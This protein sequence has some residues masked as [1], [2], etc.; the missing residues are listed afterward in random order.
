MEVKRLIRKIAVLTDSCCDIP[1]ELCEKYGIDRKTMYN[2]RKME[3]IPFTRKGERGKIYYL[4]AD[5]R[6]FFADL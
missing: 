4:P 6:A 2:Y 1:P 3:L 5:V